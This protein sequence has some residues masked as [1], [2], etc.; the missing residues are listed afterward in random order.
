MQVFCCKIYV[1][2]I[3]AM[4]LVKQKK[5]VVFPV[6]ISHV[7]DEVTEHVID[8]VTEHVIDLFT[9]DVIIVFIVLIVFFGFDVS[10]TSVNIFMKWTKYWVD[11]WLFCVFWNLDCI[12]SVSQ[13]HGQWHL[14]SIPFD[15]VKHNTAFYLFC[16][17]CLYIQKK[18]FALPFIRDCILRFKFIP[19]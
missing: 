19:F 15:I 13:W 2:L 5:K 1:S 12:S 14:K 18:G 16:P 17:N 8:E 4:L 10:F 3:G 11:S 6:W 9:K 7:T